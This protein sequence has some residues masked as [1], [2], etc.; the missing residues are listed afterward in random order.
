MLGANVGPSF[1]PIMGQYW[2][3]IGPIYNYIGP[4]LAS[5]I[6]PMSKLHWANVGCYIQLHWAMLGFPYWANIAPM[7]WPYIGP[8]SI[9]HWANV[10][11]Q[12][13]PI[14]AANNGPILDQHWLYIQLHWAMLGFPYWAHIAPMQWPYIGPMSKLHWSYVGCQCWPIIAANMGQY[15]TN[16]GLLAGVS[17]KINFTPNSA[18]KTLITHV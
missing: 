17:P 8:M 3:N 9:L 11:C 16:I 14:I 10:G 6:G 12:C 15:W 1:P 4:Y 7:Q 2:I 18:T 5:H 13:W